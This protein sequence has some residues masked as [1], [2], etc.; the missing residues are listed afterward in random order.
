MKIKDEIRHP[1]CLAWPHQPGGARRR[2]LQLHPPFDRPQLAP[3]L[4]DCIEFSGKP[5]HLQELLHLLSFHSCAAQLCLAAMHHPIF[6]ST[7]EDGLGLRSWLGFSIWLVKKHRKYIS[8]N[9]G[10]FLLPSLVCFSPVP[11][12]LE[13]DQLLIWV[14]LFLRFSFLCSFILKLLRMNILCHLEPVLSRASSW[15][16]P[17]R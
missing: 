1:R 10:E 4:T 14:L 5:P 2:R 9:L 11:F 3:S 13:R 16:M 8:V 17:R 7:R 15:E 12:D 6:A